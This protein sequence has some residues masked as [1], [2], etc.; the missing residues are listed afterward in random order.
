MCVFVL[1]KALQSKHI[2]K[3][4]APNT[5]R[6]SL[7]A[8]FKML[9]KCWINMSLV[10]AL[11]VCLLGCG[12]SSG[13]HCVSYVSSQHCSPQILI[14][15][16]DFFC[17][18]TIAA[19]LNNFLPSKHQL[20]RTL[21][22]TVLRSPLFERLLIAVFTSQ[23]RGGEGQHCS[24]VVWVFLS[25]KFPNAHKSC[26]L[27]GLS[28]FLMVKSLEDLFE[29]EVIEMKYRSRP[30]FSFS[31][32][33]PQYTCQSCRKG[34]LTNDTLVL[35]WGFDPWVTKGSHNATAPWN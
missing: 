19:R 28:L 3:I 7:D 18:V 21:V 8:L 6:L 34:Q 4:W 26:C 10:R 15:T 35:N 32:P 9:C 11:F 24:F 17:F 23:V 13:I 2:I 12:V 29:Q 20:C 16:F 1:S 5:I 22:F 33:D 31:S 25:V 14:M 27:G 30:L